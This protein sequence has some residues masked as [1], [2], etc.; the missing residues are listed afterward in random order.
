MRSDVG[1]NPQPLASRGFLGWVSL[2]T[3]VHWLQHLMTT[4]GSIDP[5]SWFHP[6]PPRESS[7]VH[8]TDGRLQSH[9]LNSITFREGRNVPRV[10]QSPRPS[11]INKLPLR[12]N[13]TH[14]KTYTDDQTCKRKRLTT[15]IYISS[16]SKWLKKTNIHTKVDYGIIDW[17]G[18]QI[19]LGEIQTKEMQNGNLKH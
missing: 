1:A 10:L 6:W 9:F 3:I 14:K 15:L 19:W 8:E 2:L 18:P 4:F 5:R 7:L 16:K 13:F 12:E 11:L 17:I